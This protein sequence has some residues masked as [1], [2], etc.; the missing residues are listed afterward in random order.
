MQLT[1]HDDLLTGRLSTHNDCSAHPICQLTFWPEGRTLSVNL[2]SPTIGQCM[3]FVDRESMCFQCGLMFVFSADE[4]R[5]FR[6][7]GFTNDPKR[8]QQCR[9]KAATG[10]RVESRVKCSECGIDTSVPFKPTGTRPVLCRVCFS[11]RSKQRQTGVSMEKTAS[12][13]HNPE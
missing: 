9:A 2:R 7:K 12:A 1:V 6:E 4:Q 8:C 3:D 13:P 10:R 11:K 5:F